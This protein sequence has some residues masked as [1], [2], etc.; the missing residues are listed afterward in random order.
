[1]MMNCTWCGELAECAPAIDGNWTCDLCADRPPRIEETPASG[2]TGPVRKVSV[3][4][5]DDWHDDDSYG[6]K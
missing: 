4:V 3:F 1:M 5:D 6:W 2:A